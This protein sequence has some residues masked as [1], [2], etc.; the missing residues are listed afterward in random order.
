VRAQTLLELVHLLRRLG[1]V[2][3]RNL[4]ALLKMKG[5]CLK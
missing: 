5:M 4:V 2:R 3:Q 1:A